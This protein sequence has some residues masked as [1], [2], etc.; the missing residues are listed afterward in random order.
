MPPRDSTLDVPPAPHSP[1]S[2]TNQLPTEQIQ[3]Q[4]QWLSDQPCS[5]VSAHSSTE[6]DGTSPSLTLRGGQDESITSQPNGTNQSADTE[7]HETAHH[8]LRQTEAVN[9]PKFKEFVHNSSGWQIWV[10]I[11]VT[12]VFGIAAKHFLPQTA[13]DMSVSNASTPGTEWTVPPPT[14]L[15]GL[16]SVH[17][18]DSAMDTAEFGLYLKTAVTIHQAI[19]FENMRELAQDVHRQQNDELVEMEKIIVELLDQGLREIEIERVR[20]RLLRVTGTLSLRTI[21]AQG[22]DA[23]LHGNGLERGV[24]EAVNL[25]VEEYLRSVSRWEVM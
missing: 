15:L 8:D 14:T 1:S 21:T 13:L 16:M 18:K 17:D 6:S 24:V 4:T 9:E 20:A 19:L 5:S 11:I 2:A 23:E 25:V 3:A 22:H 7:H 12:L 10:K